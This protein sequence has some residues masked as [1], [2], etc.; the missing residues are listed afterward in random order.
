MLTVRTRPFEVYFLDRDQNVVRILRAP[1]DK[2]NPFHKI[3][4]VKLLFTS[5]RLAAKV[6][7]PFGQEKI[8][9]WDWK[10]ERLCLVSRFVPLPDMS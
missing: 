1:V 3:Y 6:K 7:T 5:K 8:I 10:N 4:K 2:R 9:V